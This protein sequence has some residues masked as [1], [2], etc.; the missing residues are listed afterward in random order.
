VLQNKNRCFVTYR[1]GVVEESSASVNS[2]VACSQRSIESENCHAYPYLFG[3]FSFSTFCV[4]NMD[5]KY[6]AA[7]RS[8]S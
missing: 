5:D 7:L 2:F 6:N 3:R 1:Y 4:G 8:S